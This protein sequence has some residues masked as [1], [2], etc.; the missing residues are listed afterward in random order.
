MYL[1]RRFEKYNLF[2]PDIEPFQHAQRSHQSDSQTRITPFNYKT[3]KY[4]R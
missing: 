3:K 4:E 1:H 2:S